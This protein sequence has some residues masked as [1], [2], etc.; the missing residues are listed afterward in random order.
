MTCF[1]FAKSRFKLEDP[2]AAT[3]GAKAGA[4]GPPGARDGESGPFGAKDGKFGPPGA[5]DGASGPFDENDG[6]LESSDSA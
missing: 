4:S 1:L 6:E 2:D 5:K 3:G